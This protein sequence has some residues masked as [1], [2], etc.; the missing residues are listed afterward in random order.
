MLPP[1]RM[2]VCAFGKTPCCWKPLRAFTTTFRWK[3]LRGTRLIDEPNGNNVKDWA[4]SSVTS[5][6]RVVDYGGHS[7]TEPVLVCDDELAI[8]SA[9]MIQSSLLGNLEDIHREMK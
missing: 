2:R 5:Y 8:Q 4:I 6:G 1:S 9:S 7:E 3:H